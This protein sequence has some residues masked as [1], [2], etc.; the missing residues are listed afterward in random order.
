MTV[1]V[2]STVGAAQHRPRPLPLFLSM[3]RSETDGAP[4]R[5]AAALQGLRRYQQAVRP[6][7][8]AP[9]PVVASV[10]RARVRDYGGD[11]PPVLFVP[12]LINPPDILDLDEERSMLRWLATQGLRP[13]L[14]DWGTPLPDERDLDIAGHVETMLLP[15]IEAIGAD[16]M[17]AGYCLGG[18]MALAAATHRHV[19]GLVLIAAPW[20]F[21]GYPATTRDALADLWRQSEA[22]TEALGVLPMEVLQAAFWRLDPR[23]TVAKYEAFGQRAPDELASRAFV[24]LEDW[25]NDGPPLTRGAARELM[26]DLYLGDRT[27]KGEWAVAGRTIMPA[28]LSLP[29]LEIVSTSD[30]I[31]PAASAATIGERI[32]LGLGHVG[33]IVGG[34]ARSALWEPLAAW[35]SRTHRSC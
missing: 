15:L 21:G 11:G 17:L 16:V 20:R 12:S 7:A 5:L 29:T 10:G 31:V 22:A 25:A 28:G 1:Y 4:D 9:M 2:A 26:V 18:T 34:R 8:P 30:R 35:L 13:L 33:M 27:G 24:R 19:R 6:P 23:R 3:L 14:L 32:D